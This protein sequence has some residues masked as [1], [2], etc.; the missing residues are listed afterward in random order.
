MQ[1]VLDVCSEVYTILGPG[2]AECVYQ[3]S[4]CI[5]LAARGF[6]VES[7]VIIPIRFESQYVGSIRADL[8]VDG[9]ICV[10]LKA[11]AGLGYVDRMQSMT[12]LTHLDCIQETLLVNFGWYRLGAVKICKSCSLQATCDSCE[13]FRAVHGALETRS[14]RSCAPGSLS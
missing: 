3:R 10:E 11:K 14:D 7:E 8:I 9:T 12:Y 4:L 6:T 2:L 13:S 1:S 5:A